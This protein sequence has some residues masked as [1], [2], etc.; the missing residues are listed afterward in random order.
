MTV[1][2]SML[3]AIA[4]LA[5]AIAHAD[6]DDDKGDK[7]DKA[8]AKPP[9]KPTRRDRCA[10]PRCASTKTSPIGSRSSASGAAPS[11]ACS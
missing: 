9:E 8:D 11:I 6:G 10:R 5:P 7:A 1:G 2:K 4:L 3:V